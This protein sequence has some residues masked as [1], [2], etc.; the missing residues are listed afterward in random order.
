MTSAELPFR[1]DGWENEP[2]PGPDEPQAGRAVLR[3]TYTGALRG[4]ATA[5]FLGVQNE[6]AQAYLAQEV[7]TG[8]LDGRSGGF[9]LHH[10]ASGGGGLEPR[11]WA[12]VVPGS[13]TGELA[14]L[15]GEGRVQHEL[16]V[17]DYTLDGPGSG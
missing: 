17:L 9:V 1:I 4:T 16:L 2:G 10:G 3:K 13:G 8:E 7:I 5:Y 14:S 15:R 6:V 12:F 11:Q